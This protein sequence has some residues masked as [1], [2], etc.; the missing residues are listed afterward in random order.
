MLLESLRRA[1]AARPR[2]ADAAAILRRGGLVAFPTETVYGLGADALNPRALERIFEAK[3]RPRSNPLILH[4]AGLTM[5]RGLVTE[6]PLRA[7]RL[8]EAF[9]PG[10]LTLILPKHPCVPDEA[11]A[12]GSTV[13][14]RMPE[15]PLALALLRT[16]GGPIAAPSAN[17][18]EHV[19]PT[20]AE[21]VR[22][23][24]GDRVDLILDGGPCRSGLESTVV[25]LS[26]PVPRLLRPGPLAPPA[27]V[28]VLGMDLA[29][30]R[31]AHGI[32]R[33]PGQARRHYA[34]GL[35]VILR[36]QGEALPSSGP[37][38]WMSLEPTRETCPQVSVRIEMPRDPTDYGRALYGVLRDLEQLPLRG[39]VVDRPPDTPPWQAVQDRL[40]RASAPGPLPAVP[41]F[42][43]ECP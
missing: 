16:F 20:T 3:G 7:L 9:W 39:L 33:S 11:T 12:G 8:M 13:A 29:P 32:Q 31:P 18:S 4:V 35:P 22:A 26:G 10:P 25:D 43:P 34:P 41:L 24:L 15:H 42:L 21:H 1:D 36:A 28:A 5:A 38:G 17:R 23:D 14:L 37:L 19:S 30:P 27:L 6:V 40:H 2:L